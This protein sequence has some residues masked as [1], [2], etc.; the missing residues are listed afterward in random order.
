MRH[1]IR[2]IEVA[3]TVLA[4]V[5]QQVAW[6]DLGAAI[7]NLLDQVYAFLRQ[8][9]VKQS[10]HNVCIYHS[11]SPSGVE[12][13]VGV[14]VSGPFQSAGAISCSATPAGP[15]VWTVHVGPYEELG[16]THDAID[17]WCQSENVSRHGLA[18]EVYGDWS[19]KPTERRTDIYRLLAAG[20]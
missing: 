11:P 2:R 7:P 15:S 17:A 10:G 9:T 16:K 4:S 6:A 20:S 14:Q 18:W 3:P 12:I 8:A 13:E 1:E 19:D 5:R